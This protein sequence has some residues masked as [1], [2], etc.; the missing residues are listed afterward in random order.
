MFKSKQMRYFLETIYC[1]K[2]INN[3]Y[4]KVV[5]VFLLTKLK[6]DFPTNHY[7]VKFFECCFRMRLDPLTTM[8]VQ[9]RIYPYNIN[10]TSS[11]QVI[12]I[13]G[14]ISIG[15]LLVDSIPNSPK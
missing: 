10:K 7:D 13:K 5:S 15:G 11:K 2:A 9:N 6:C 3:K 1:T 12:R 8:S 14:K 4:Q